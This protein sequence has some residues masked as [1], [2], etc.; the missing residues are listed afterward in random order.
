MPE[1]EGSSPGEERREITADALLAANRTESLIERYGSVSQTETWALFTRTTQRITV[2][3]F[4]VLYTEENHDD[5]EKPY[6]VWEMHLEVDNTDISVS[7]TAADAPDGF[8]DYDLQNGM[9]MILTQNAWEDSSPFLRMI[10]SDPGTYR[11]E[12]EDDVVVCRFEGKDGLYAPGR[13]LADPESLILNALLWEDENG[14][15]VEEGK[16]V[17]TYGDPP[18]AES[19]F[20]SLEHT[21]RVVYHIEREGETSDLALAWPAGWYLTVNFKMGCQLFHDKARTEPIRSIMAVP[22]DGNDHEIWV[23]DNPS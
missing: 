3:G 22:A 11:I 1:A 2:N 12:A 7:D 14:K 23:T 5:G 4:Y 17:F 15:P 10:L 13:F 9:E 16:T 21:R 6:S 19:L 20:S 8:I 18:L